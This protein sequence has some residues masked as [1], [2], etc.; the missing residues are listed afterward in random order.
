M[1]YNN[2]RMKRA[3]TGLF[4]LTLCLLAADRRVVLDSKASA[5]GNG[6]W[7]WTVFIGGNPES[8]ST[9]KCV[10]YHFDAQSPAQTR[11][12]C[13]AGRPG[14]AFATSGETFSPFPVKA[15]VEWLDGSKTDLM[16]VVRPP[17]SQ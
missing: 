3:L 13:Q 4:L 8:P 14:L 15:T 7:V 9:V 16:E 12:T 2:R 6:R 10:E 5:L 17:A 11:R 1:K